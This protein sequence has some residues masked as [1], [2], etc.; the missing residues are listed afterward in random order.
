MNLKHKQIIKVFEDLKALKK[1]GIWFS[2]IEKKGEYKAWHDNG[3]LYIQYFCNDEGKPEG[4][5]KKWH[6]NGKLKIH[7]FFN[8]KGEKEG[9]YKEWWRNGQL[10]THKLYRNNRV[11][12]D[13]LE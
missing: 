1:D 3:Q 10:M 12:K 13:Y 9:E 8:D 11:I 5:C 4:E 6:P 7:C 2:G